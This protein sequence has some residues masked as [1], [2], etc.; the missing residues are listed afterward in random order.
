MDIVP[1]PLE[2][3]A[4]WCLIRHG[5]HRHAEFGIRPS[6]FQHP[7]LRLVFSRLITGV[8]MTMSPGLA[9]SFLFRFDRGSFARFDDPAE[10]VRLLERF[11]A[12]GVADAGRQILAAA[13]EWG[14]G[15]IRRGVPAETVMTELQAM[16]PA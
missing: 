15:A 9:D 1:H 5:A 4:I 11:A 13:M 16:V 14:A 7:E 3:E 2:V 10:A 12:P 8:E 6:M